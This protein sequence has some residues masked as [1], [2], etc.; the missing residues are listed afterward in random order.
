M[1]RVANMRVKGVLPGLTYASIA[2]VS[3]SMPVA[4]VIGAGIFATRFGSR[5]ATFGVQFSIRC[6]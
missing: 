5:I 2:W 3:A 1:A 6:L 4:A